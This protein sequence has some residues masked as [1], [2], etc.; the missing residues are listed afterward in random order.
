M[1]YGELK[2]FVLADA[3]R[4]DLTAE[5]AGYVRRAE[6]LIR[7]ELVGYEL[8]ATLDEDDRVSGGVY[9]LPST[10]LLV[11][12]ITGTHSGDEYTLTDVGLANIKNID[13]AAV[14]VH[15]AIRAN[16]VEFRGVPDTDAAFTVNYFGHPAALAEDDDEN[17]LLTDHEELYIAGAQFYLFLHEQNRELA[18][19]AFSRFSDAIEKLNEAHAR[20]IGG[21]G[22]VGAYNLGNTQIGSSY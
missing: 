6:G 4:T 17:D 8:S 12:T 5:I 22:S 1:N 20:K 15:Y 19:D 10:V 18:N 21:G 16:T 3:H 13:D 2:T 7:R 14:P 11:R 9:T